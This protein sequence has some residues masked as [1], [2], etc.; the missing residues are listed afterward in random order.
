MKSRRALLILLP[1]LL[2]FCSKDAELNRAR[3]NGIQRS[4]KVETNASYGTG[5]IVAKDRVLTCA[6]LLAENSDTKVDGVVAKILKVDKE[7]D[8]VLLAVPT[9]DI[10]LIEIAKITH[11]DDQIFYVGNPFGHIKFIS[12]GRVVDIANDKL[13]L[14][15]RI[16]PGASGSGVYNYQGQLVGVANQMQGADGLGVFCGVAILPSSVYY[17][18]KDELKL[19]KP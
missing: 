6:H 12:H 13:Y 3:I 1:I 15:V 10:R 17:F 9:V 2:A 7:R 19:P 4:V 16:F 11:Q 14:D 8:L 18:L 5:I